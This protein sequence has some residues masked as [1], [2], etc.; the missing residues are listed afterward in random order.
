MKIQTFRDLSLVCL[1]ASLIW[2]G[3]ETAG[4]V[5]GRAVRNPD[6]GT[7]NVVYEPSTNFQQIMAA[8]QQITPA[9]PAP[10]G[11]LAAGILTAVTAGVSVYAHQKNQH[12][13]DLKTRLASAESKLQAPKS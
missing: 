11:E 9:I 10:F 6:T 1:F 7:T 8:A 13:N 3:V 12:N 5:T 4:C 2:L